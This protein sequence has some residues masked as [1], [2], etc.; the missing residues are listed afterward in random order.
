MKSS[1]KLA[2]TIIE[3]L[4]VVSIISIMLTLINPSL[5]SFLI[6]NRVTTKLNQLVK[7][8]HMA[9]EAAI[10]KNK[11]TI[12]C[13]SNSANNCA[14]EWHEG[15]LLFTDRNDNKQRDDSEEIIF[16]L[17]S[18]DNEDRLY[19]RAFR[20]RKYLQMTPKGLTAWQN[21]TFTYCPREGLQHARGIILNAAG[22]IKLTK[23][24]NGDGVHEGANGKTIRC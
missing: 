12:L 19:W 13:P 20:N 21:G 24:L 11:N 6:S 8:I 5:Q 3:M 18:Y 2:F 16:H 15:I 1:R 22:R 9:R 10:Y 14:G 4:F 7:I 17:P 23:D